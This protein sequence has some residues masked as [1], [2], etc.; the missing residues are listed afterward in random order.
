MPG[1]T[2]GQVD[3]FVREV[4]LG[5]TVRVS[6]D[7][8]GAESTGLSDDPSIS[9]DG[10][11]VA[12]MSF[13]TNLVP[14]DTNGVSDVFVRDVAAGLTS[15]VSLRSNG[16]QAN[17]WS[18]Q[19][20]LSAD[21]QL[22]AFRSMAGNLG[23]G[24]N[25]SV[26]D[27]FL[28]DRSTGTTECISEAAFGFGSSSDSLGPN[29][30]PDGRFVCFSSRAPN[31]VNGDTNNVEDVFLRDR[32]G[33]GPTLARTGAC[34]GPISLD[35]AGATPSQPVLILSGSSGSYVHGGPPCA[36]LALA[37]AVP[38]LRASPLADASG[39]VH[40]QFNAPAGVCGLT[41][42]AVDLAACA[43]TNAVVL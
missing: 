4:L 42:Q 31:L 13:A 10:M 17:D 41:I 18:D 2:N 38:T 28:H 30:T 27:L 26:T 3:V 29:L 39:A 5:R 9:A 32:G 22:V 6:V 11:H 23:C 24:G 19:P 8:L 14:G 20:S 37:I 25:N 36:G 34:P 43:P 16:S 15:R 7:S 33:S 12:F 40:L 1:D 35:V 21:G